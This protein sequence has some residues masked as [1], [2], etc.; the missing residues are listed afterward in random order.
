MVKNIK[1]ILSLLL[2][3][4]GTALAHGATITTTVDRHTVQENESLNVLFSSDSDVDGEP[5][6]APLEKD[7]RILNRSQSSNIQIFNGRMNRE[8]TW[9]L[10]LM[11][12]RHGT[13]TIPAIAFGADK[14]NPVSIK[15]SA[16]AVNTP[17]PGVDPVYMEATVDRDQVYVQS[18][19][20]YTLRIFHAVRLQSGSL[21]DLEISDDNAIVEKL[22]DKKTYNKY[23][24]GKRYQVIEKQ[25]AIFPQTAGELV[26]E[27]AV[28]DAQFIDLPRVL[29]TKRFK[30]SRL[31][32]KVQ[33][34]PPAAKNANTDYWLPA[35]SVTLQEQW[36]GN[37]DKVKVGEPITRTLTLTAVGLTAAQLP[38]LSGTDTN[39]DVKHYADQ[40]VL[41]NK[42]K[43]NG[44]VGSRE[45]KVAYI[46]STPGSLT[47]PAIKVVWW[48]I[49]KQQLET[50]TVPEKVI[51]VAPLPNSAGT[52]PAQGKQPDNGQAVTPSGK[53]Q[54][55]LHARGG[56][57][58]AGLRA[59]V[60]FWISMV[61]MAVWLATIGLWFYRSRGSNRA[62]RAP[63][64]GSL[65]ASPN[66]VSV[67]D[68]KA[69]CQTNNAQQVKDTLIQWAQYEWPDVPPTSIGHLAQRVNGQFAEA[70]HQ[71]NSVLY[72]SDS[73]QWNCNGLWQA[74]KAYIDQRDKKAARE[75]PLVPPLYKVAVL[76][77]ESTKQ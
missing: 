17:D 8:I 7:F 58:V 49:D 37:S 69:A 6:F 77:E 3:L 47:L 27:P 21:S 39:N 50:V 43:D 14:S 1:I 38:E 22:S 42:I 71:L 57:T 40:P 28:L 45:E 76:N 2:W 64:G 73:A 31:T 56:E 48:N 75:E 59:R 23:I 11:P 24:K 54:A 52:G 44:F 5:D 13:L 41:K 55:P 60:W 74:A 10:M 72:K 26:I 18:Q 61:L 51:Q 67:K 66:P 53:P 9:N 25:Y 20:V 33:P 36:S 46:A 62:V 12:K 34:V 70:L 32:V 30:T 4:A 68:I 15:V 35:R 19:L 29:R 16:A 63:G 65:S